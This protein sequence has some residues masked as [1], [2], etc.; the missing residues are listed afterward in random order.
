MHAYSLDQRCELDGEP[1]E[2]PQLRVCDAILVDGIISINMLCKNLTASCQMSFLCH[3]GPPC[4]QRMGLAV[5]PKQPFERFLAGHSRQK[6]AIPRSEMKSLTLCFLVVYFCWISLVN[7]AQIK[8]DSKGSNIAFP[9]ESKT[10]PPMAPQFLHGMI[11]AC[12]MVG[13]SCFNCKQFLPS[14]HRETDHLRFNHWPAVVNVALRGFWFARRFFCFWHPVVQ[15]CP[16]HGTGVAPCPPWKPWNMV[17]PCSPFQIMR[18][19]RCKCC[20]KDVSCEWLGWC[21]CN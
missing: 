9:W 6:E 4:S 19:E 3:L 13:H 17:W 12:L 20:N 21:I 14:W 1:M 8:K 2:L 16:F 15:N 7:P 11:K 18:C 10:F 5:P